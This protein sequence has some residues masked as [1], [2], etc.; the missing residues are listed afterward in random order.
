MFCPHGYVLDD[1][2]HPAAGLEA[3]PHGCT[4][5]IGKPTA[6]KVRVCL[7]CGKV[8]GEHYGWDVSCEINS[9]EFGPDQLVRGNNGRVFAIK[10]SVDA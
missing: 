3:C 4:E 6:A 5:K 1:A 7:A 10:E 8:Q 2:P 9:Q